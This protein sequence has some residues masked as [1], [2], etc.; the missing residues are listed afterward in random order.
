MQLQAFGHDQLLQTARRQRRARREPLAAALRETQH[1]ELPVDRFATGED[2]AGA[3]AR[4]TAFLRPD[5]RIACWGR[6]AVGL[7]LAEGYELLSV[8]NVRDIA[9]RALD[10]RGVIG[11]AWTAGRAGRRIAALRT[12]LTTIVRDG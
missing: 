2:G 7:L 3:L 10:S 5:D 4:L 11:P 6:F 1:L 8:V 9:A 12:I